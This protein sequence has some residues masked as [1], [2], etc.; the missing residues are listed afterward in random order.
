MFYKDRVAAY[1]VV[2][3]GRAEAQGPGK[4]G[5]MEDSIRAEAVMRAL[6]LWNVT[7]V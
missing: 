1:E 7:M 2:C 5:E 4:G 3:V 6:E